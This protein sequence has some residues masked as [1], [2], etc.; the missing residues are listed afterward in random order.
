ME[1]HSNTEHAKSTVGC[2]T[3]PLMLGGCTGIKSTG[4]NLMATK[5]A[6]LH[7]AEHAV[8]PTKK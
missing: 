3:L 7:I 2:L 5:A 4:G 8:P 1:D 6:M